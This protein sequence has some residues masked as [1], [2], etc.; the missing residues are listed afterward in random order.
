MKELR[1]IDT[2]VHMKAYILL[3][4]FV[5]MMVL[6]WGQLELGLRPMGRASNSQ[7]Y[8]DVDLNPI[9][10]E[11]SIVKSNFLFLLKFEHRFCRS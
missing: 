9:S 1:V 3:C 8:G 10:G 7:K 6:S 4:L 5:H 2:R 11:N